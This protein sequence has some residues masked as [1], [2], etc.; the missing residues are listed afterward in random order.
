MELEDVHSMLIKVARKRLRLYPGL[1]DQFELHLKL[2]VTV[3]D[4]GVRLHIVQRARE[5]ES[6]GRLAGIPVGAHAV[7]RMLEQYV[8][9]WAERHLPEIK[10]LVARSASPEMPQSVEDRQLQ[11]W[12][13]RWDAC[14]KAGLKMPTKR[15]ARL[16][17]G[18]SLVA[19]SL[20]ISREALS[21]D[22][23]L[24]LEHQALRRK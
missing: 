22:L 18:I 20:G 23:K 5:L 4:M 6:L 24:Y 11:R 3:G 13:H 8:D 19:A 21:K 7:P 2:G 12:Q 10:P 16:P 17:N 15:E 9:S 14:V 1:I